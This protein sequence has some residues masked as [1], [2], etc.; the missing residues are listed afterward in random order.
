MYYYNVNTHKNKKLGI[1]LENLLLL[2]INCGII[3]DI[4]K[5]SLK[6]HWRKQQ[7]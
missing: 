2:S 6:V 3:G 4:R 5:K 1:V 7:R